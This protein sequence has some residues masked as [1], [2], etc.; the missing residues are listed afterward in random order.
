[1]TSISDQIEMPLANETEVEFLRRK[2]KE[3]KEE[4]EILKRKLA[5]KEGNVGST[6]VPYS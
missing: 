4:N 2:L 5:E 1:M 6:P 3:L